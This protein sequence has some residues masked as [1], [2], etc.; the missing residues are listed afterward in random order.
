MADRLIRAHFDVTKPDEFHIISWETWR[1]LTGGYGYQIPVEQLRRRPRQKLA[2]KSRRW[3]NP[4]FSKS[5]MTTPFDLDS[6]KT[7]P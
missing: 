4:R 2:K 3:R 6:Q 7:R 5:K 1:A